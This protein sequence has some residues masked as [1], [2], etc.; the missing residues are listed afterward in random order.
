MKKLITATCLLA[1]GSAAMAGP[2]LMLGIS[3]NFGG[4]TGL[5]LKVLST[6]RE[7]KAAVAAG[8]TYFPKAEGRP[9]GADVGV[10]YNL[11]NAAVTIGYDWL[12]KQWQVGAGAANTRRSDDDAANIP[13][14]PAGPVDD[15]DT[16]GGGPVQL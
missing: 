4:S 9:W 16:D 7:H 1:T 6:N 12:N 14:P 8:I 11:R 5:T 10:G 13:P 3:H 2:M 15:G